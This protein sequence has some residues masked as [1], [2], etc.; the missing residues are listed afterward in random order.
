MKMMTQVLLIEKRA[1]FDVVRHLDRAGI[2]AETLDNTEELELAALDYDAIVLDLACGGVETVRRLR[3]AGH[4]M[5]IIALIGVDNFRVRVQA[6]DAGA[7][8]IL[9]IPFFGVE[10]V[11]RIRAVIRRHFGLADN[12]LTIGRMK[13]LL[14]RQE[15]QIDGQ[16]TPALSTKQFQLLAL[17]ARHQ[18]RLVS[19]TQAIAHLYRGDSEPAND[20]II[21]VMLHNIRKKLGPVGGQY[22]RTVHGTGHNIDD[23]SAAVRLAQRLARAA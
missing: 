1:G 15:V 14:D 17:L 9:Q 2:S 22:L 13:V 3:R 18:G 21:D 7:D 10:L 12:V 20:K 6:L 16:P 19:K 4:R 8:D 23:S 5:P 11:A